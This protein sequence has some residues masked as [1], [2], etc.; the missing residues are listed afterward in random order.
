MADDDGGVQFV[1]VGDF[2]DEFLDGVEG[3]AIETGEGFVHEQELFGAHDLLADGDALALAAGELGGVMVLAV[4]EFEAFEEIVGA[5]F[6]IGSG[7]AAVGTGDHEVAPDCPVFEERVLLSDDADH[8]ALDGLAGVAD[9]DFARVRFVEAGEDAEELRLADAGG[10][11][12]A[13]DL[14]GGGAGAENVDD[15]ET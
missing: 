13:D 1:G 2:V 14:A 5:A 9:E 12:E 10:A 15:V 11:E 4:G 6:A 7:L 3:D 8:A